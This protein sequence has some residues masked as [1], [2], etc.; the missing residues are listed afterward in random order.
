[1]PTAKKAGRHVSAD[2]RR[3]FSRCSTCVT[4]LADAGMVAWAADGA[5]TAKNAMTLRHPSFV[6]RG[7]TTT[8]GEGRRGAP[9][10]RRGGHALLARA[11][12]EEIG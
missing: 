12:P 6:R 10:V 5:R 11:S 2:N 9:K 4:D 3:G 8:A 7:D 1:M